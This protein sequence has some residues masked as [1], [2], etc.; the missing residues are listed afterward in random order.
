MA[1]GTSNSISGTTESLDLL[2]NC[3]DCV[4][5]SLAAGQAHF[6]DSRGKLTYY[7]GRVRQLVGSYWQVRASIGRTAWWHLYKIS[8]LH[9]VLSIPK[10]C[11]HSQNAQCSI[12]KRTKTSSPQRRRRNLSID[13]GRVLATAITKTV[14]GGIETMVP[15]TYLMD[16][17]PEP[18]FYLF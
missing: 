2:P 15:G 16:F 12:R 17:I 4:C 18:F 13:R 3:A 6:M 9:P 5:E 10:Y 11:K 7:D 8:F 1:G 14:R